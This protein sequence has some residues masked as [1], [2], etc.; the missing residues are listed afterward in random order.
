[1][2]SNQHPL[3]SNIIDS[4]LPSTD[5]KRT[6]SSLSSKSVTIDPLSEIGLDPLSKMVADLSFKEKVTLKLFSKNMVK[7]INYIFIFKA[8]AHQTRPGKI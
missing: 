7:K 2:L 3:K 1:V 4:V 8:R 6:S 5:K